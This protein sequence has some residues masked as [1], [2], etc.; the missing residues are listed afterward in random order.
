MKRLPDAPVIPD[1]FLWELWEQD[2]LLQEAHA[3][4]AATS[5]EDFWT[6]LPGVTPPADRDHS[7]VVDLLPDDAADPTTAI[8]VD[9]KWENDWRPGTAYGPVLLQ[10]SLKV[11]TRVLA[12]PHGRSAYS[13]S[14]EEFEDVRNGNFDPIAR[15]RLRTAEDLGIERI[16]FINTS[17]GAT[18]GAAALKLLALNGSMEAD[19]A[20]LIEPAN[21]F[22]CTPDEKEKAVKAGGLRN[23]NRARNDSAIPALTEVEHA[24]GGV[25]TIRQLISFAPMLFPSRAGRAAHH[26][27]TYPNFQRDL[28]MAF[29]RNEGLHALVV[30]AADSKIYPPW[31][32]KAVRQHLTEYGNA[33]FYDVEG[34]GHKL[35]DNVIVHALLGKMA[36]SPKTYQFAG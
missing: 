2:E 9:F 15:R 29:E 27:F 24:R 34:Y 33:A 22:G 25:D 35:T 12:F 11:P 32:R 16:R 4:L 18:V 13:L 28:G 21:T 26:G 36:L 17:E 5:L 14:G 20:A 30:S 8:G 10:N 7:A 19:F 6:P 23:L 3:E 31:A 1:E